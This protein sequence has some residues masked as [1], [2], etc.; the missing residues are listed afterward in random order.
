MWYELTD[1]LDLIT[2]SAIYCNAL[3]LSWAEQ[4]WQTC[5]L[6]RW[7]YTVKITVNIHTGAVTDWHTS[8]SKHYIHLIIPQK[9]AI[10]G[11]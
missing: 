5:F 11:F 9:A 8:S 6:F 2:I 4:T 3:F 7:Q 1:L 10:P